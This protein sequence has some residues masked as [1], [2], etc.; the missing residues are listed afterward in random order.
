MIDVNVNLSR[1]PFRRLVGD[2]PE[3]LVA[4]LRK[5][6]VTR[7]W[8]GTFD[9]ILHKDISS[10]NARLANDCRRYGAGLLIPFGSINLK[11]PDW[12]EDVRRCQEDYKMP[13]IRLHPNY[14]GYDLN[15]SVFA[16]L[17]HVAAARKL[18]VQLAASMEDER[19]QHPLMR[20]APVDLKPL[21]ALLKSAPGTRLVV[22]NTDPSHDQELLQKLLAAGDVHF[23]ISMVEGVGGVARLARKISIRRV[24][25]G[26]HY[27]L[28]YFESAL[29]KVREAGFTDAE[30]QAV[31]EENARGLVAA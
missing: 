13:G 15:D 11:L 1:W 23:D 14:H 22:L 16:D 27:P 28:F 12:Q 10:A 5:R 7:A 29:L 17:L 9:G 25:F 30:S 24:L 21:P 19:T 26:S 18:I 2:E 6:S 4:G 8:A 20:V 3:D 31:L